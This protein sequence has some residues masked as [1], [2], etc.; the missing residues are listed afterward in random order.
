[1]N[2]PFLQIGAYI[3]GLLLEVLVIHAMR[4]GAYRRYPFLFLYVIADF[5]TTVLE[6]Q[7]SLARDA[8][9]REA[10]HRWSLIYWIDEQIIQA[11][12]FLLVISL[13]YRAIAQMRQR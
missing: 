4:Q 12:L 3:V 8:G 1:M 6:I 5:L 7:P 11:L 2:P 13:V 10:Q 9:T